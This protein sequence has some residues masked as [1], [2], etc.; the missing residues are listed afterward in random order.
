[1]QPASDHFDQ[2]PEEL[3]QVINATDSPHKDTPD[4][5]YNIGDALP[6]GDSGSVSQQD[7]WQTIKSE[8]YLAEKADPPAKFYLSSNGNGQLQFNV[9]YREVTPR[10]G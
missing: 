3:S 8:K 9:N 2:L 7:N 4:P 10:R 1:M 6:S 5:I